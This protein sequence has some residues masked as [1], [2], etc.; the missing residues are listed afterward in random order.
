M[1]N[2]ERPTVVGF[3]ETEAG[4]PPTSPTS[5]L[6]VTPGG[7][8]S[9]VNFTWGTMTSVEMT[10]VVKEEGIAWPAEGPVVNDM[11]IATVLTSEMVVTG[12]ET[13]T[14]GVMLPA[15]AS[16]LAEETGLGVVLGPRVMVLG[17]LVIIPG[18]AFTAGAQIPAK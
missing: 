16:K 12:I 4:A 14:G 18:L 9:V 3:A 5:G 8:A 15:L 13:S 6:P 17:T 7:R 1:A 2:V 11:G 10:D